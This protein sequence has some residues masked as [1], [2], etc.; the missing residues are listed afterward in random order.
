MSLLI[1]PHGRELTLDEMPMPERRIVSN[2]SCPACG[3]PENRQRI[4]FGG[5]MWC[6]A[7]ECGHQ[8]TITQED[9]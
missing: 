5:V 8:Y 9:K 2:G 7:G 1:D 6:M 3:A 4:A